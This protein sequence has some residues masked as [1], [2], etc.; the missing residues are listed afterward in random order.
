MNKHKSRPLL[1][2]IL[3]AG[4]VPV[5]S[6]VASGFRIP[7]LSIAGLGSSNAIVADSESPGALPYNPAAMA[8]HDKRTVTLGLINAQI[9]IDAD[10]DIGNA[11]ESKGAASTYLPSAY[12]MDPVN[13]QLSWG[14]AINTPFGAET[15]WPDE[16]FAAY[17]GPTDP[18]EPEHSRLELV[19][20]N[21]NLA[22]RLNDNTSIAF[23]INYHMVRELIFNTQSLVIKGDGNGI[24]WNI[25]L[26]HKHNDWSFGLSYR[27]GVS[28]DL[29]GSVDATAVGSIKSSAST[30]LD[31]P[32]LLQVGAR[33][34]L[35]EDW[36]VEFDIERT[37]WSSFDVIEIKHFSP[38]IPN[39]ITSTN[40]WKDSTAYRLSG[41]FQASPATRYRIGYAQDE[42]P[43]GETD[44]SPRIPDGDRQTLSAGFSHDTG[45]YSIEGGYMFVW[46]K[47]TVDSNVIYNGKYETRVHLLGIGLSKQF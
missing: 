22:Y 23:G 8:F 21:P 2:G 29:D 19:N 16:T 1:S 18:F 47:R 14:I 30:T 32:R 46:L 26:L 38:G 13:Q 24:G 31:L 9:K 5:N 33:Y 10:P 39:P 41:T 36:S 40:N 37:G 20:F 27:S 42:T 15:R 44:F 28:I 43:Q 6:A 7:E 25:G 12:F 34:Q 4:L 3:I 45:N 35:N 17:A 11:T